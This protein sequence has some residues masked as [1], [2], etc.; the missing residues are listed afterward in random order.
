MR[1][2]FPRTSTPHYELFPSRATSS[3]GACDRYCRLQQR[4]ECLALL[5][6][7][8]PRHHRLCDRTIVL[9]G[10]AIYGES[11]ALNLRRLSRKVPGPGAV[12]PITYFAHKAGNGELTISE[13]SRRG[14]AQVARGSPS[15]V[16]ARIL[17]P[18]CLHAPQ[19]AAR[20]GL[21]EQACRLR[22]PDEGG[23]RDHLP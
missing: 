18:R 6:P 2:N 1:S 4:R 19:P 13:V 11:E 12:L 7:A 17:L 22:P 9:G 23:R 16:A 5:S 21:P 3:K 15:R 20:C 10:R 14:S 8:C